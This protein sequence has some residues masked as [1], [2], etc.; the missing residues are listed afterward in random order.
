METYGYNNPENQGQY[1]QNSENRNYRS[2]KKL[3]A[4]IF[5]I[6][7]GSLGI[8]KFYMGYINEGV[9][10]LLSTIMIIPIL[11][12]VTCGFASVIY[13]VVFIIPVIEGIIYL[14]MSDEKFDRTY[15]QNRKTWF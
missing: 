9:I 1:Q 5:A 8:H 3:A 10:L 11:T 7:L 2:E 6:L 4:G 15:I 13:P 12:L 14:T